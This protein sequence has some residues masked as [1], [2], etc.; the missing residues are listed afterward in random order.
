MQQVKIDSYYSLLE[1]GL[2]S[3]YCIAGSEPLQKLEAI[4]ALKTKARQKDFEISEEIQ[5]GANF[6]WALVDSIFNSASLFHKEQFV[7]LDFGDKKLDKKGMSQLIELMPTIEKNGDILLLSLNKLDKTTISTKWFGDLLKNG[8]LVQIWTVEENQLP[9]WLLQRSKKYS[10]KLTPDAAKFLASLSFGNLLAAAGE[11]EKLSY[12]VDDATSIDAQY[13]QK[14]TYN[15]SAYSIFDFSSYLVEGNLH[16]LWQSLQ[17]FK[18]SGE[19]E[20][21]VLWSFTKEIR[22][23]HSMKL[24]LAKGENFNQICKTNRVWRNQNNYAEILRKTSLMKLE[25]I[26]T[27]AYQL[28]CEIKSS[29]KANLWQNLLDLSKFLIK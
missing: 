26:L 23:L 10:Y 6:D 21:L 16:K 14:I 1:Q 27:K 2:K 11:L 19:E 13:L 20:I 8:V 9:N 12:I 5:V 7:H 29:S 3:C 28:D 18:L 4:D 25:F 22:L 17:Y 15:S 24:A